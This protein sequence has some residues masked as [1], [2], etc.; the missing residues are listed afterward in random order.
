MTYTQSND[1][2]DF[3]GGLTAAIQQHPLPAALVGMGVV[4]LL[5]G[6]PMLAEPGVESALGLASEVGSKVKSKALSLGQSATDTLTTLAG[7]PGGMAFDGGEVR[8][9]AARLREA[10]TGFT[11]LFERQPL[12]LGIVGIAVG[13]GVAATLRMG[14]PDTNLHPAH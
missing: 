2:R 8:K 3:V 14:N 5:S 6:R 9:S 12:I 11:D 10:I 13:A 1:S 7:E 4:W